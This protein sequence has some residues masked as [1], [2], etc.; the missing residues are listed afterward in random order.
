MSVWAVLILGFGQVTLYSCT[1]IK[2]LFKTIPMKLELAV[3]FMCRFA[4]HSDTEGSL[5]HLCLFT[6]YCCF[7]KCRKKHVVLRKKSY[8]TDTASEEAMTYVCR[9]S[10][11]HFHISQFNLQWFLHILKLCAQRFVYMSEF[12]MFFIRKL[13]I[14]CS[15]EHLQKN[16]FIRFF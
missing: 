16:N 11:N 3:T 12:S 13:D 8:I 15:A 6:C 9:E 1:L 7:H 5:V 14:T 2:N 4:W 10:C